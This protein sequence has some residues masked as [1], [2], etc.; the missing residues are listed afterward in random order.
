MILYDH[1]HS[2]VQVLQFCKYSIL[3][4]KIC[5]SKTVSV[6]IFCNFFFFFLEIC[7]F[8]LMINSNYLYCLTIVDNGFNSEIQQSLYTGNRDNKKQ[9]SSNAL[10]TTD[11]LLTGAA[12]VAVAVAVAVASDQRFV[13]IHQLRSCYYFGCYYYYYYYY[14]SRR[15]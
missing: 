7:K 1:I 11:V 8:F 2:H 4:E 12:A 14:G 13:V 5:F 15:H 9:H 3:D 10:S 6:N